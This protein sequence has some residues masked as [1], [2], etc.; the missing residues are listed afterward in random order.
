MYMAGIQRKAAPLDRLKKRYQAFQARMLIAPPLP[1]PAASPALALG[2]SRTGTRTA[3][4]GLSTSTTA[5][6]NTTSNPNNAKSFA[7]F[8]DSEPASGGLTSE[9]V[10]GSKWEEIGTLKSRK[11]ENERDATGWKGEVLAMPVKLGRSEKLEVF[12]D[13]V[14]PSLQFRSF[15]ADQLIQD[16][17]DDSAPAAKGPAVESIVQLRGPVPAL[18][19]EHLRRN[20]FANYTEADLSV[21]SD[22]PPT[23]VPTVVPVL[24]PK[25]TSS[26]TKRSKT[27]VSSTPGVPVPSRTT[28]PLDLIY[29]SG[30]SSINGEPVEEYSFE[31]LKIRRAAGDKYRA[32]VQT[33]SGWADAQR[34][35]VEVRR[36]GGESRVL[37]SEIV[38]RLT[39]YTVTSWRTGSDG[40]PLLTDPVTGGTSSLDPSGTS[41]DAASNSTTL[42]IR[43]SGSRS[44]AQGGRACRPASAPAARGRCQGRA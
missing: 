37:R 34:W 44:R 38:R 8:Q 15:L 19:I 22:R 39:I 11:K 26:K 4:T 23:P 30:A 16:L 6:G 17:I 9:E 14:C 41:T 13:E 31:E 32:E 36:T 29:P 27:V 5:L 12:V 3:L 21:E 28:C 33:W 2:S 35:D 42:G 43:R 20:P 24:A 40:R 7:V 1:T 25:S 10:E 18:D